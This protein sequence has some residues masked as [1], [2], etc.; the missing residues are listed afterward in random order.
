MQTCSFLFGRVTSNWLA[1]Y[2]LST[3]NSLF[4]FHEMISLHPFTPYFSANVCPPLFDSAST[5]YTHL[6]MLAV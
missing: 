1:F 3:T 5:R 2:T 6:S 4:A